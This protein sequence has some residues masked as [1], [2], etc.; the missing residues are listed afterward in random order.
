MN[1]MKYICIEGC[2]GV[3]KTTLAT[4][5]ASSINGACILLEDFGAHPFLED[6]YTDSKYTF[7]T[8]LN[9]LLIHY[10]QLLKAMNNQPPLLIG[11][12]FFGKDKLFADANILS[13]KEIAIFMQLYDYLLCKLV[14]PDIIVCL[15][16]TTDMIYNRILTRNRESEKNVSYDYISKINMNYEVFFSEI[17]K[18]YCTVDIDMNENDFVKNPDLI[19]G[20][21]QNLIEKHII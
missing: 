5:L 18:I 12:Y 10:H 6:F 20:L 4:Q 16:G 17:R 3:G 21:K 13:E 8:E 11:D 15:S 1:A 7:E 9:F 14:Q 19:T 2:I